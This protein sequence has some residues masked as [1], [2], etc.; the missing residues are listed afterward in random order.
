M[1][2]SGYVVNAPNLLNLM[3]FCQFSSQGGNI[4][5]FEKSTYHLAEPLKVRAK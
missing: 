5:I 4:L 3:D 2:F 1:R